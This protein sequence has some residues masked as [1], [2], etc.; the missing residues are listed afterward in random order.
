[1]ESNQPELLQLLQMADASWPTGAFAFSNGLEALVQLGR[2]SDVESF[3]IYLESY[4]IQLSEADLVF[5]NSAF[6]VND[7]ELETRLSEILMDWHAFNLV[8]TMR[9]A[10]ILSGENWFRLIASVYSPG[11]ID[12]L[13]SFFKVDDRPMYFTIVFPLLLKMIGFDLISIHRI[14]YHMALRD[15]INA[16]IRLGLLGPELAQKI[17]FKFIGICEN[18]RVNN[19]NR[20]YYEACRSQPALELAQGSHQYLYSRLFQN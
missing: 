19:K 2:V 9:K 15:Q 1:M 17:H 5:M 4:L 3:L 8:E 7:D 14:F 18:L 13:R 20:K 10:N 6:E 16:A 11:G 12:R